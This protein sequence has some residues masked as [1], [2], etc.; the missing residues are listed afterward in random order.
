MKFPIIADVHDVRLVS[1]V[2]IV[3]DLIGEQALYTGVN[4]EQLLAE[5]L[6]R[7]NKKIH[8]IGTDNYVNQLHTSVSVTERSTLLISSQT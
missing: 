1:L 8:A 3:V 5:S 4:P 2:A 7:A 6:Y